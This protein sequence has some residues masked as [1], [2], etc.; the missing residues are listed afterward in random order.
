MVK[1]ISMVRPLKNDL[2]HYEELQTLLF[3]TLSDSLEKYV[4]SDVLDL[5]DKSINKARSDIIQKLGEIKN[6]KKQPE[7]N[8][9]M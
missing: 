1:K 7:V 4:E 6:I 8:I 2:K 5:L 3:L 9:N